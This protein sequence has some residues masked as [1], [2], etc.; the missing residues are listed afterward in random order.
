ME[1]HGT[2]WSVCGVP[3]SSIESHGIL[4]NFMECPSGVSIEFH[5]VLENLKCTT[6]H[7]GTM[8][9]TELSF[10]SNNTHCHIKCHG[11]KCLCRG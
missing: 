1:F 9:S 5:G 7:G 11:I 10:V 6:F 3:W 8:K 2:P 4:F